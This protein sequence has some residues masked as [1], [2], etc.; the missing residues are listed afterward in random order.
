MDRDGE[1]FL[2]VFESIRIV[3]CNSTPMDARFAMSRWVITAR[4]FDRRGVHNCG[5]A[6]H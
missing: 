6:V 5:I 3:A 4:V 1:Y 2:K